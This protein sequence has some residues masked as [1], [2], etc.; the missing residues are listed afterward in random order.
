MKCAVPG[1]GNPVAQLS[2]NN[3]TRSSK[4]CYYHSGVVAKKCPGCQGVM[5]INTK[6]YVAVKENNA[7]FICSECFFL[8]VN[9]GN[10]YLTVPRSWGKVELFDLVVGEEA[11][12]YVTEVLLPGK[13]NEEGVKVFYDTAEGKADVLRVAKVAKAIGKP[14]EEIYEEPLKVADLS[15]FKLE[16]VKDKSEYSGTPGVLVKVATDGTVLDVEA[17]SD[18]GKD[19]S[20]SV[21]AVAKGHSNANKTDEQLERA[22]KNS[23]IYKKYRD[24]AK[25]EASTGSQVEYYVTAV[26]ITDMFFLKSVELQYAHDHKPLFWYAL[27]VNKF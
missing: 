2:S 10:P 5:L 3:R 25:Y 24:I 11:L 12:K 26:G 8:E 27:S 19:V 22:Y 17:S 7:P 20:F 21:K 14:K 4:Y 15:L 16:K 23:A 1:C 18:L 9:K 13:V 6:K